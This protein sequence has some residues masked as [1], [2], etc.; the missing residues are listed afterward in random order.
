MESLNKYKK[1]RDTK[2][3]LI[4]IIVFDH[5]KDNLLSFLSHRL[6]L[7]KNIK[8]TFKRKK[9]NDRVY[10]LKNIIENKVNTNIN[11][12]FLVDDDVFELELTKNNIKTLKDYNIKSLYFENDERFHV[13]YIQDLFNDFNFFKIAEIDKKSLT[14]Y[15]LNSTKRR[16]IEERTINNQSELLEISCN[17]DIIHGVSTTLK[18]FDC[19]IPCFSKKLQLEELLN[20]I[21]K[22]VTVNS[23]NKLKELLDNLE[24]PSYDGKIFLGQM[25]TK[26]Y[27]EMSLIKTLY[28]HESIYKRFLNHFSEYINFD[29]VEIKKL[30]NNDISNELLKNYDKCVGEL[31]YTL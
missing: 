29:V 27:T 2:E 16:K 12:I 5:T 8:D 14:I 3:L 18:N 10:N 23:H 25:E 13:K 31:Y 28:I 7:I 20:E 17:V 30:E 22:V 4:T 19:K 1:V 24:N 21:D 6:E 11:S 26:K 15:D 9:A